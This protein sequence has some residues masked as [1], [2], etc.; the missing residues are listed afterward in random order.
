MGQ[1]DHAVDV[2]VVGQG[3]RVD[4]AAE[5]VGD[6]ARDGGRTVHRRQDADVVA[7]G[8]ATVGPHDALERGRGLDIGGGMGI[9]RPSRSRAGM[10]AEPPGYAV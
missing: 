2:G 6:G 8:D 5:V 9:A 7:R 10:S 1:G 3:A 4:V